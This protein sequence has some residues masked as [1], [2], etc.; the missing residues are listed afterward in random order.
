MAYIP[1]ANGESGA[2]ARGKINGIGTGLDAHVAF[3]GSAVHNLK[4]MSLQSASAVAITGGSI[5]TGNASFGVSEGHTS[6]EA[7][8]TMVMSGSATVWDD[9]FFP[10]TT[11]KQGQTD[12]PPFSTTEVAYLYPSG[13][14]SHIMYMVAQFPH[15]MKI[16]STIQPH[17][18]WKQN[19]S[20]SPVFKMDYKWHDI[21]VDSPANFTTYTMSTRAI[22]YT[23]G[24]IH[25]L[26]YGTGIS[27]SSITGI[28]SI[29]LIKLY[30]DDTAYTGDVITYQF[31]IHY[32]RDSL[33]SREEFSK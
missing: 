20:G 14:T 5:V 8:G 3:T 2:D 10:L 11:A 22:N 30:R 6:F 31:D 12:K 26:N 9:I 4:S 33:G 32:L 15:S 21:G 28:S 18:H 17:V 7:D 29:M 25:Q 16:G 19:H 1:I 23:S 24:S 13:D 27:G